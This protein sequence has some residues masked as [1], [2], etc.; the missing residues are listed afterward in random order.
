MIL[1]CYSGPEGATGLLLGF[2]LRC[3]LETRKAPYEVMGLR[4]Y[5][6]QQ[7][8]ERSLFGKRKSLF[9]LGVQNLKMLHG[10]QILRFPSVTSIGTLSTIYASVEG[11]FYSV[12]NFDPPD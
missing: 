3:P 6:E 4:T 2:V 12:E 1:C 5:S 9:G 10:C 11:C 7:P 8:R